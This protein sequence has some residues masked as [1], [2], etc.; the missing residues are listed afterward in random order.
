MRAKKQDL[1]MAFEE[2]KSYSRDTE[3]GNMNVA[4]E[5]WAAGM[6]GTPMFKGLPD[7]RCQSPHWGYMIKGRIRIKYHDHDEVISAGEV[8]Y[9][10][11]GH[12]PVIEEDSELVEFSPMGEYQ[13]TM[14]VAARNMEAMK[15]KS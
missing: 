15:G 8:Y 12:I 9:L 3:W 5:E 14:E 7:D 10:P 13:K 11:P 2:G 4:W 6:D 1:P